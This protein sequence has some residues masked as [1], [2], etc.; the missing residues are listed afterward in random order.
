VCVTSRAVLRGPF[1]H[2]TTTH[3]RSLKTSDVCHDERAVSRQTQFDFN[4]IQDRS[5]KYFVAT[6]DDG[7]L[8]GGGGEVIY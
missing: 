2:A 5:Y 6:N 1:I 3:V 7:W 8:C 4:A